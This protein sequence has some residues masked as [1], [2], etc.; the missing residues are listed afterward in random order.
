MLNRCTKDGRKDDVCVFALL[1][2]KFFSPFCQAAHLN[3]Y[4]AAD[5]LTDELT[6]S[7]DVD[8]APK[9]SHARANS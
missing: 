5:R 3:F 4:S 9:E 2:G 8:T 6:D 7:V 1:A